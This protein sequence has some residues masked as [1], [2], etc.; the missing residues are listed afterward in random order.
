MANAQSSSGRTPS[1]HGL[2]A[3]ARRSQPLPRCTGGATHRTAPPKQNPIA[4][5]TAAV[6]GSATG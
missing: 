6:A 1:A 2:R 4:H 3:C 5:S